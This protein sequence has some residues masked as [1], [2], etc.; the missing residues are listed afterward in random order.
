MDI[1][2]IDDVIYWINRQ[3]DWQAATTEDVVRRSRDAAIPDD[4]K[5]AI[6]GMPAGTWT[7]P[8]LVAEVRELMVA[9]M[10]R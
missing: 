3:P 6:A 4:A 7:R 8:E 5:D 1:D 10:A 9:K 2:T